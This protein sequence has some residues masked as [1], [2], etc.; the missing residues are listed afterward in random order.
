MSKLSRTTR[1]SSGRHT[2]EGG[3]LLMVPIR[4]RWVPKRAHPQRGYQVV[5][6]VRCFGGSFSSASFSFEIVRDYW[7]SGAEGEHRTARI[8][9]SPGLCASD[10]FSL[11]DQGSNPCSS[12]FAEGVTESMLSDR[13]ALQLAFTVAAD[14]QPGRSMLPVMAADAS[15]GEAQFDVVP[16]LGLSILEGQIGEKVTTELRGFQADLPEDAKPVFCLPPAAQRPELP[17][18]AQKDLITEIADNECCV[19]TFTI[20]RL[21]S[22]V[23]GDSKWSPKAALL[24]WGSSRSTQCRSSHSTTNSPR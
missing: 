19:W 23:R 5:G 24:G 18:D 20:P 14:A 2:F 1:S 10:Y 4:S 11:Q 15:L 6:R 16:H 7:F 21:R 3:P 13:A 17:L 8:S 9:R 22:P 12:S